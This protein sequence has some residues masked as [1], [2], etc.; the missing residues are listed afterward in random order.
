MPGELRGE[1]VQT[2]AVAALER[3]T[4]GEEIGVAL[5]ERRRGRPA[6]DQREREEEGAKSSGS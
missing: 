6:Q 3:G 2:G 4:G 5:G 1:R